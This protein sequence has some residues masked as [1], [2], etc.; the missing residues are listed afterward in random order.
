MNIPMKSTHRRVIFLQITTLFSSC[1]IEAILVSDSDQTIRL[2]YHDELRTIEL[3]KRKTV[4]A[5]FL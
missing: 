1:S 3:S 4:S 5:K 2:E